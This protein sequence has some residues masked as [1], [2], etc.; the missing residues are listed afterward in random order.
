MTDVHLFEANC[1]FE[2][3]MT[4]VQL[5]EANCSFEVFSCVRLIVVLK[6]SAV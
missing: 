6:Y 3:F 5:C 4:D 2:V 1:S